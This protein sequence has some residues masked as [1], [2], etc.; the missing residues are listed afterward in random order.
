M[1]TSGVVDNHKK[2]MAS[3]VA[4]VAYFPVVVSFSVIVVQLSVVV[5]SGTKIVHILVVVSSVL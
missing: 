5:F 2:S 1:V 3:S 4:I